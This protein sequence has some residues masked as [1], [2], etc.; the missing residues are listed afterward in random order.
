[1]N[2]TTLALAAFAAV[3]SVAPAATILNNNDGTITVSLEAVSANQ[4]SGFFVNTTT[5]NP[6]PLRLDNDGLSGTRNIGLAQFETIPTIAQIFSVTGIDASTNTITVASGGVNY[7]DATDTSTGIGIFLADAH[8]PSNV[9]FS[10]YDTNLGS[11]VASGALAPGNNFAAFTGNTAED[12]FSSTTA[13]NGLAFE[14]TGNGPG[15][16]FIDEAN[17]EFTLQVTPTTVPEPSSALLGS[18][19]LLALL[20]RRRR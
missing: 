13:F 8:N 2:T 12:L 9:T 14:E 16:T 15:T 11:I 19:G 1:M 6:G 18:F 20:A 7:S 3:V 10:N 5:Q 17:V 4:L